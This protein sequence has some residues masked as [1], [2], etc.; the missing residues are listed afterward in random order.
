MRERGSMDNVEL[1][2]N[3][4]RETWNVFINGEWY[5][6]SGDYEQAENVYFN[7]MCPDDEIETYDEDEIYFDDFEPSFE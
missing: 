3:E 1:V 5:F 2:F 6:E 4:D 7:C